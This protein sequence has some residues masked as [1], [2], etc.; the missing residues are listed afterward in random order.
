M[1]DE[2]GNIYGRWR[3]L[4]KDTSHKSK[5]SPYWVCQCSC[6]KHT[7]KSVS[8]CSLRSGKS[9]SCGCLK[10]ELTAQRMKK[11]NDE[12]RENIIGNKYGLLTV[13]ELTT[14]R[15][16]QGQVLYKCLCD[17]G[18]YHLA[19][20]NNLKHGNVQSCGCTKSIIASKIKNILQ[21]N[22][23]K[24]ITEYTFKDLV[25][26]D[27]EKIRL[28]FDFAI[29]DN[30]NSLSHLIEYDGETHFRYTNNGWNN[31]DNFNKTK[32]NDELKNEYCKNHNIK[33][34]RI[35]YL[36]KDNITLNLLLGGK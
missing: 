9:K 7:I 22:N 13:I 35:S 20:S 16:S 25:S 33:L 31:E 11:Y 21:E 28:R 1:V 36:Q 15:N 8:L 27:N 2:T 4:Y 26:P 6:D 19:T 3:V 17:C 5:N 30:N 24:F 10:K 18:N 12:H 23:I 32:R 29:F 14:Q 34:I